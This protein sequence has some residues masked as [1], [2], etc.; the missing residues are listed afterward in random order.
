MIEMVFIPTLKAIESSP[1][2][3]PESDINLKDVVA[4]L[5]DHTKPEINKFTE[6]VINL[7][8]GNGSFDVIFELFPISF[9][10]Y[11]F[12]II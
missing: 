11:T 3:S 2:G 9:R 7:L 5:V 6:K 12:I 8:Y 10:R 1:L 4:F